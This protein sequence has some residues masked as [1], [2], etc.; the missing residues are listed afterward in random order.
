MTGVV[1]RF[2]ATVVS[3]PLAAWLLPGVHAA[4]S[5]IAWI[6]GVLLGILYLLLRP[7]AKLLLSP[8]NCLTFGIV[9]FLVDVGFVGLAARWMPGFT[10]DG[11]WWTVLVSL[12]VSV[13]R[14]FIGRMA[15]AGR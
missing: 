11:F 8:F 4:N 12:V 5:Q 15:D 1:F 13:L 9:G 2:C 6:A 3:M 14:E 10:I 7:L